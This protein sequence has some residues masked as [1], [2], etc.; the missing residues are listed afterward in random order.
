[1]IPHG[2][3]EKA[4]AEEEGRVKVDFAT[5]FSARLVLKRGKHI[6]EIIIGLFNGEA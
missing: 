2:D 6:A 5:Y 1:M 3:D 4:A